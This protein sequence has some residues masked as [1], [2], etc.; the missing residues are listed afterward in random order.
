MK[1][2][3]VTLEIIILVTVVGFFLSIGAVV[4]VGMAYIEQ[5][6]SLSP[7]DEYTQLKYWDVPTKV[8]SI[9]NELI[10][11]FA[12]EKRELVK[13]S[14][15][16]D[17]MIKATI[18]TEDKRFYKHHGIDPIRIVKSFLVNIKSGR[19]KQGAS[20]ITQQLAKN[21][22]LTREKTYK[23]KVQEALLSF[24]IERKYTKDEILERYLNKIYFGHGAHGVEA[25]ANL[26]FGKSVWELNIGECA[27]LAGLPNAPSY[28]SPIKNLERAKNRQKV[29]LASM[30]RE[31]FITQE[32][33]DKAFKKIRVHPK[34]FLLRDQERN[35]APYFT[36]YIRQELERDFGSNAIYKA[37]LQVYTT[38]DLNMNSSAE[39]ALFSG[40]FNLNVEKSKKE[41]ELLTDEPDYGQDNAQI[42]GAI[43]AID[44][45]TGYIK[46]MVGGSGF[47]KANQVN[48]ATQA[49]R[50]PGSAF[51]PFI[52]AAA[53]DSE[54]ITPASILTDAEVEYRLSASKMWRPKNYSYRYYGDVTVRKA[55]A[56]S[57]NIATIKLLEKVGVNN[58]IEC[59]RAMGITS[60]LVTNLSLALGTS[61]VT[62]LEL[63]SAYAVLA[64]GGIRTKP[65][66]IR[67]VTDREGTIVKENTVN[68]HRVMRA[69]V[70][71]VVT[72]MLQSVVREGTAAKA[73]GSKL[74]M[75]IAGKTG[76]TDEFIDAWF[77]GYTPDIA[78]SVWVGYD[79]GRKSL[80]SGKAGGV[81]AAPIWTEFMTGVLQDKKSPDF[82]VPD[83]VVFKTIDSKNGLIATKFCPTKRTEVFI[84]GTEPVETCHAHRSDKGEPEREEEMYMEDGGEDLPNHAA[85]PQ[86]DGDRDKIRFND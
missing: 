37:G 27:M 75:P 50:Q 62:P 51:K 16:P 38:L 10:A 47:E 57:I 15:I 1:K 54:K 81:V 2:F 60:P 32:E 80:G 42:E 12:A 13:L 24:K 79:K 31:K 56:H 26:Y 61:E 52:Y 39:S 48:R 22:F 45:K 7:L 3:I 17:Y 85:E 65:I 46:V 67:Y 66:A 11:E 72:N 69:D 35:K 18:A 86:G 76:T 25:A 29:V 36:E 14:Q 23:R 9:D 83:N 68:E 41:E 73:V 63:T 19:R 74:R 77:V 21:L 6:P 4:G 43:V 30:V 84:K 82:I 58:A 34:S 40:L 70:A 20:T 59:A 64:N 28:Y 5:L 44:P 8:Y 49:R 55:L 71:F 53:I 33:A 78:A